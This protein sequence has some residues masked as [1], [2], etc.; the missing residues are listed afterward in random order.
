MKVVQ[1]III[2]SISL[3]VGACIGY[4]LHKYPY[5]PQKPI[6]NRLNPILDAS[7]FGP[8]SQ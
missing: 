8:D 4:E 1:Y 2:V 3:I 6:E 7:L 5:I